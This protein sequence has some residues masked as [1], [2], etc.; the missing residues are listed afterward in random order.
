MKQTMSLS[1]GPIDHDEHI[2]HTHTHTMHNI[3]C[4][5]MHADIM[6]ECIGVAEHAEANQFQLS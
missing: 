5:G 1:S 3:D 4:M 6:D 2:T